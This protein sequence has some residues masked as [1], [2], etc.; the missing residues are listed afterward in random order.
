VNSLFVSLRLTLYRCFSV[1]R[2]LLLPRFLCIGLC[3]RLQTLRLNSR[4]CFSILL[5]VRDMS[6][7]FVG[8]SRDELTA[9]CTHHQR[10]HEAA[11]GGRAQAHGRGPRE[12]HQVTEKRYSRVCSCATIPPPDLAAGGVNSVGRV[13]ASQAGCRGFESRTP[14]HSF[15]TLSPRCCRGT[16]GGIM[17][18]AKGGRHPSR[19]RRRASYGV[20]HGRQRGQ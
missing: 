6:T 7:G 15:L 3:V 4:G 14:L 9:K 13:L 11:H 19:V 17:R 5:A 10:L 16:H 1:L 2:G 12:D 18:V 8:L 20:R